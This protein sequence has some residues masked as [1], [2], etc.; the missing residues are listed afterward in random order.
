MGHTSSNTTI[1]HYIDSNVLK[2]FFNRYSFEPPQAI[3]NLM[4]T[5]NVN[6]EEFIEVI[7]DKTLTQEERDFN[8]WQ[9]SL[10]SDMMESDE[11]EIS[12]EENKEERYFL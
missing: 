2:D 10:P 11:I 4:I 6:K 7:S 9:E 1:K 5:A 12:G 3:S 8:S